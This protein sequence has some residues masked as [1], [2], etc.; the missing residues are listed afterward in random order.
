MNSE[1]LNCQE[2]CYKIENQ[3]M[4]VLADR[5]IVHLPLSPI[6]LYNTQQHTLLRSLPLYQAL[7]ISILGI[8]FY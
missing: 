1:R 4:M 5:S 8:K 3:M 2:G 7:A 6:K